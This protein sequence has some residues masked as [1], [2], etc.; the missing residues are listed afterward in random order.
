VR[1]KIVTAHP[2]LLETHDSFF[3][4][5]PQAPDTGRDYEVERVRLHSGAALLKLAGCDD[6]DA[7]EALRGMLVQ[8]PIEHAVQLEEG[9]YYQHQVVGLEVETV[10][11]EPLGRLVE[12]LE[13]GANDVY[14]VLGPRGEILIP[15][16]SAVVQ[17]IDLDD[18]RMIVHP[19]PGLLPE[20]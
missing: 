1:A 10:D 13:T 11:G 17:R 12:V 18:G 16:L 5:S 4:A 3:L 9:E 6:R 14:I 2:D 7:A 20:E 19:L 8:V 15:A